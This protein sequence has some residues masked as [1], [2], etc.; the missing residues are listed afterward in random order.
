MQVLSLLSQSG[1]PV[2]S[3][4]LLMEVPLS[5][6]LVREAVQVLFQL[7]PAMGMVSSQALQ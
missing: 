3:L 4:P 5:S 1:A 7:L 2:L 6:L